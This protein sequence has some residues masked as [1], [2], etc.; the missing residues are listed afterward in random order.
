MA[1]ACCW[2]EKNKACPEYQRNQFD[3]WKDKDRKDETQGMDKFFWSTLPYTGRYINNAKNARTV[4]WL[5]ACY[6]LPTYLG[7]KRHRCRSPLLQSDFG[8]PQKNQIG[9]FTMREVNL[10]KYYPHYTQ[11]VIVEVSDEIADLLKEAGPG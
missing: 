9:E 7:G 5:C 2:A 4:P 3:K 1:R 8:L 11:D 6:F 10:R